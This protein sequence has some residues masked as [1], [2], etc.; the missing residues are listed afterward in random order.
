MQTLANTPVP[1]GKQIEAAIAAHFGLEAKVFLTRETATPDCLSQEER[2]CFDELDGA[3]TRERWL[4][5]RFALKGV[6]KTLGEPD[7]TTEIRF[8]NHRFS[9]SHCGPYVVAVGLTQSH[10]TIGAG[11]DLESNTPLEKST[12]MFLTP[13]EQ[14]WLLT[15]PPQD[16]GLGRTRLWA[17]K[18]ALFKADP[19][20]EDTALLS[21][22]DISQP[23]EWVGTARKASD[24]SL[25]F[26]YLS[27]ESGGYVLAFA[28]SKR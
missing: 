8:P 23:A 22:Y 16:Q 2:F 20:N 28:I 26:Q 18:E 4:K 10:E 3:I 27:L 1:S 12:P 13:Q 24:P 19:H 9:L 7:E 11:I 5:G 21:R 17:V 14:R 15:L 6:L 25:R